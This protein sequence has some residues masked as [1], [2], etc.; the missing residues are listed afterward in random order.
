[1]KKEARL[2][3][4]MMC[5][6]E[7]VVAVFRGPR[8][9]SIEVLHELSDALSM[10]EL[11]EVKYCGFIDSKGAEDLVNLLQSYNICKFVVEV[12]DWQKDFMI[13]FCNEYTCFKRKLAVIGK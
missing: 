11:G 13:N 7:L 5:D 12:R 10:P 1:M 2:L 6:E 9:E 8:V 3:I 4:S